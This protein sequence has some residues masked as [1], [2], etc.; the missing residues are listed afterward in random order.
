[1]TFFLRNGP[2]GRTWNRSTKKNCVSFMVVFL[3]E[4]SCKTP[5]LSTPCVL[6]NHQQHFFFATGIR[7]VWKTNFLCQIVNTAF[8]Q[9]KFFDIFDFIRVACFLVCVYANLLY[10]YLFCKCVSWLS[11]FPKKN[12]ITLKRPCQQRSIYSGLVCGIPR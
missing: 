9:Q 6:N 2:G 7:I 3:F 8:S 12:W 4:I 10:V 5:L 11:N 1:M